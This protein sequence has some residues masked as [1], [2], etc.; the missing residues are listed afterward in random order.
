MIYPEFL[1][2]GDTIAVPAPSSSAEDEKD[3]AKYKN[4][5]R[6]LESLGYK[7]N[8]SKNIYKSYKC[9]SADAKERGEELTDMFSSNADAIICAAGGEFLVESLSYVDFDKI[10]EN[11]K[12]VE[13]FSDPTGILFPITTKYDIATIYGNNFG[14]FGMED[15]HEELINNLEILKGNIINQHSFELYEN[16]RIEKVTGLE[17]YNLTDKVY[18]KTLSNKEEN[19]TGRMICGCFDLIMEL[20]GTKYDGIQEFNEKYKNDGIIFGFDNCDLSKEEIIRSLWKLNEL[21]YFKYAKGII[22]GRN[23]NDLPSDYYDSIE[24]TLKDSAI[25]KLNIPVI[26]DADISHKAPCLTI[27]NGAIANVHVKDGKGTIKFELR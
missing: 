21:G 24:E 16:E 14:S 12:W 1:K 2:V 26:Y 25:F 23:G 3:V 9:R 11:P 4:A 22:F 17:G 6:K 15:Y 27:I 19:I 20:A 5:K 13:G 18:W 10:A 8:V 7:I